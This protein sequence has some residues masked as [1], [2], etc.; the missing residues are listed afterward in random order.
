MDE[1]GE[2]G[3]RALARLVGVYGGEAEPRVVVD[4]HEQVLPARLALRLASAVAGEAVT[5][6][7]DA[8]QFLAVDVHEFAGT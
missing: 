3:S 4:R 5:R 7:Q 2:E 6:P 1:L 8:S